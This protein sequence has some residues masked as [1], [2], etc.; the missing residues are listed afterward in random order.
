MADKKEKKTFNT[1]LYECCAAKDDLRT[2]F[3]C[4]HFEKGYAMATDGLVAIKQTLDL[5]SIINPE[6]LDGH[7]LHRDSYRAI[8]GFEIAEAND[9][10]VSCWNDS[11]AKAFFEYFDRNG[12]NIPNIDKV[13]EPKTGLTSLTF[14]GIDPDLVKRISNAVY[15]PDNAMRFQFQG[16]DRA[17]LVDVVGV[18]EQS[19]IIMPK[20]LNN[21]LF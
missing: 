9:E 18:D 17:I 8:M 10:G 7:S 16:V 14:I 11:G 19:A 20:I 13:I 2:L 5:Q 21:T 4:V 3:Q 6:N 15:N 12:Q 1:K